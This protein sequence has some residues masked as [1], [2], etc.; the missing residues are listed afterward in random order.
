MCT[1]LSFSLDLFP[2]RGSF[3]PSFSFSPSLLWGCGEISFLSLLFCYIF[4]LSLR[5]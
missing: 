4:P 3:F 1:F 2:S 5:E